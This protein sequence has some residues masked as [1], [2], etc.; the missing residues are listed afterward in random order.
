VSDGGRAFERADEM[1]ELLFWMEGEGFGDA[2]TLRGIARFLIHDEDETRS[3]LERL[4]S[5]GDVAVLGEGERAE[6]RLTDIGREEGGRRFAEQ[7]ASLLSQGHAECNDPDCDCHTD[8]AGAD[9][10][11]LRVSGGHSH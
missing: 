6:Y 5:R 10:R 7:F 11:G 8:P 9:C 4:V 1:L 3:A 2:A